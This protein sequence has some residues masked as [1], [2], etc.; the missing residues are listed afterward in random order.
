MTCAFGLLQ[1]HLSDSRNSCEFNM[2]GGGGGGCH[3]ILIYGYVGFYSVVVEYFP[4]TPEARV[5]IRDEA[6]EI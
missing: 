6:Y 5:R 2:E 1:S 3:G 4:I